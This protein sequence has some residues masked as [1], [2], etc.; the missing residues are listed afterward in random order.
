M[1]NHYGQHY[2]EFQAPDLLIGLH[3]KGKSNVVGNNMSIGFGVK[4]FD[5]QVKKLT[6]KGIDVNVELEGWIRLA[7]FH[8]LD[9]NA[10][11]LA[12]NK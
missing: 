8:D 6:S 4:G 5:D 9:Q 12:E 3:P 10:L 7:H 11:F 2:A 1:L